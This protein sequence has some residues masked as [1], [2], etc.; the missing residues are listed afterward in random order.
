MSL[1]IPSIGFGLVTAS[2]LAIAALGF[3]LQ[4][5][6]TNV[7]NLSYGALMTLAG[8]IAYWL[9][10]DGLNF[11]LSLLLAAASISALSWVL[12]KGLF[13]PFIR[14]GARGFELLILSIAVGLVVANVLL[15]GVGPGGFSYT[16]SAGGTYYF[17]SAVLNGDQLVVI[18]IAVVTMVS[19]HAMLAYTQ[20]GRAIRAT[21]T[22][23]HLARSCGIP[24]QR[25]TSIVW[26][27]SG[28]LCGVSGVALFL[29]ISSFSVQSGSEVLIPI[30]AAAVLGGIGQPYGAMLGALVI[31]LA[32]EISAGVISPDYKDAAAFVI[33]V[34]VLLTRPQGIISDV[35]RQHEVIA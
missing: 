17:A 26:L 28:A 3:T 15:A 20:L 6:I 2:I 10:H 8:F 31:G 1:L 23:P 35:A 4:F 9:N 16:V 5:G 27:L 24:I 30:I 25:V 13:E 22:N 29:S 12:D 14:R 32:S 33:L 7:L 18:G 19:V 34:L 11:W 21:A